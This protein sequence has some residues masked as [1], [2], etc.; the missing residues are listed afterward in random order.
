MTVNLVTRYAPKIE[1]SFI[2][3]SLVFGKGKAPYSFDGIRTV[4]ALSPTTV[5]LTDYNSAKTDGP[6]FGTLVEMQDVENIYT[7]TRD[8]SFNI[9]IDRG[10]NESQLNLKAAGKMMKKEVDEQVIPELDIYALNKYVTTPG[11]TSVVDAS[12]TK[13]NIVELYAAAIAS[14]VNNKVPATGILSWIG[15]TNFSKLVSAPE[16]LNLEKLGSKAVGK[17][18]VGEVQGISIIRVPDSYMPENVNFVVAHQNVLMP[19]KKINTLRIKEDHDDVDGSVL[20]GRI[21]Y[22]AFVLT[23]KVKGVYVSR[24][25][26]LSA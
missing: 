16:F 22:D 18:L 20:Q 24:S 4:K 9:A 26:A 7:I 6:R 5:P 17:G 12:V 13:S 25:Q 19:V 11:V 15:A 10:N 8:R 23:Q 1:E 2:L 3:D 14:L 21:M